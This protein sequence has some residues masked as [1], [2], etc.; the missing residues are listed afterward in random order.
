MHPAIRIMGDISLTFAS[1]LRSVSGAEILSP[2]DDTF[3][4]ARGVPVRAFYLGVGLPKTEASADATC[5]GV[6]EAEDAKPQAPGSGKIRNGTP[7]NA[8]G[9]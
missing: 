8:S 5:H 1:G 6:G 4:R 7:I 3:N 2:E 9:G